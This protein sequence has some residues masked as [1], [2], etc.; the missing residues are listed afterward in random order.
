MRNSHSCPSFFEPICSQLLF[1]TVFIESARDLKL[2]PQNAPGTCSCFPQK[3]QE[4]AA[5]ENV[6]Q[7][8][9]YKTAM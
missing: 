8:F 7:S 9:S 3:C 5:Y 1:F 2:I 6:L 4:L